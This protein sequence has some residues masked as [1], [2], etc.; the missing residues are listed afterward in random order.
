MFDCCKDEKITQRKNKYN[1]IIPIFQIVHTTNSA[2][3]GKAHIYYMRYNIP[4]KVSRHR[5]TVNTNEIY[6][7][8]LIFSQRTAIIEIPTKEIFY[9]AKLCKAET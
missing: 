2:I 7:I 5:L 3:S 6:A 1:I 9:E 4:A 8:I